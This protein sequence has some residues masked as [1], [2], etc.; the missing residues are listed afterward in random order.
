M[1]RP[2]PYSDKQLWN[3]K[4]M[5]QTIIAKSRVQTCNLS[6]HFATVALAAASTS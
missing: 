4:E 5:G 3:A 6:T 1:L 2:L